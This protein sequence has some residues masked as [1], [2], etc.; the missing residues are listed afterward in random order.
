MKKNLQSTLFAIV[1]ISAAHAENPTLLVPQ[2]SL[3]EVSLPMEEINEIRVID[4]LISATEAQIRMEKD[5]K[6]MM[7]QYKK[8]REEFE[9]GNQT[10][11]QASRLVRTARQIS[12]TITANHLEHLFAKD[13]L[14]ELTFFSSIAGKTSVAR[15]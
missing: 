13:Y 2:S 4:Q 8:L 3:A 1:L 10:K 14:D 9:L 7:V 15:P 11:A 5:L 12:E 6:E